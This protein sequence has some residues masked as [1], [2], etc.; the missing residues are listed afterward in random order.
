MRHDPYGGHSELGS[1]PYERVIPGAIHEAHEGV[2]FIDEIIHIASLQ[3]YILSAMQEKIF[4]I[5]G[6][7][8]QSAG[9]SVKVENVPCDFIFVAACNLMDLRYIL[10]PPQIPY[11]GRRI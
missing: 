1:A 11:T 5:V 8:P 10:P 7:N 6:R 9:S 4:P 2:L 3:R